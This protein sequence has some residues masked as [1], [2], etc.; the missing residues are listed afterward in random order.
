MFEE[1]DIMDKVGPSDDFEKE[2]AK[3]LNKN[4]SI[5]ITIIEATFL[6]DADTFGK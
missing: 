5:D 6:K 4:C 1:A 2:K 3:P